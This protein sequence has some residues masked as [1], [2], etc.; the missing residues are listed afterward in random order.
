MRKQRESKIKAIAR[1]KVSEKCA[2]YKVLERCS[3]PLSVIEYLVPVC[4]DLANF[5]DVCRSPLLLFFCLV[6]IIGQ[7]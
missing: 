3:G 5:T 7:I 2:Y 6:F 1:N 4:G